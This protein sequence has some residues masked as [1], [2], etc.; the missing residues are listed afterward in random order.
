MN[1]ESVNKLIEKSIRENWERP[2][3]SNYQGETLFYKDVARKIE[4]MHIL[5]ELSGVKQGDKVAISSRNQANWGV[6]FFSALTYGAVPVPLLHEFKSGTVHHLVNHCEARVLFVDEVI[7]E[8]LDSA[9]MPDLNFVMQVNT[10]S[11][12]ESK[13]MDPA[14]LKEK[15]N[16]VF[17]ERFPEGV[18]PEMLDYHEDTAD[19]LAVINYT[20]GTSGFSKGV[21]LPYRS[22]YSNIELARVAEPQLNNTMNVVS[23][24]P[25]AHM[26]GLMYEVFYEFLVGTHVHF[27]SRVS[28]AVI[29]GAM[30]EI[31]P[32]LVVA[33]PLIIEKVYKGKVKPVIEKAPIKYLIKIPL[34]N[35][36]V[37]KKVRQ[38]LVEAFGGRF[39]EVIIGGAA[40]NKEVDEFFHKIHFPYTVGYGMT[41]CAPIIG[42]CH[43]NKTKLYS[44]GQLA[45]NLE[46]KIDS[47]DP[48]NVAGEL[49]L[50]GANVFQGYYRNPEA[51]EAVF[52]EDGWFRTGDMGVIDKDGF[53]FLRGRNKCMILGPSGQNIYPEEIEGIINNVEFVV[54]SLVIEDGGAM[55]AL[56]FPDYKAAEAAGLAGDALQKH[57][58]ASIAEASKALPAFSRVKNVQLMAEDFERTPKK[59][60]KR[61][62]YQKNS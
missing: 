17:A 36:I 22:F 43:W 19:E 33:V 45:P 29:L 47:P 32:D 58:A 30:K 23:M 62:L 49:M 21:M 60:I 52:T 27:L 48:E 28:P 53:I 14:E 9:E 40:L 55:T 46:A 37:Y 51:T 41:E 35:R 54:E 26:Y 25:S 10:L 5:F 56:V 6:C 44:C 16:A 57:L 34:L 13:V 11:I 8:G 4:K 15:V 38:Q 20:S 12:L 7:W 2:S 59:S 42:Y 61:Y 31:K 18:K 1:F 3:L 39:E 50:K 24:L